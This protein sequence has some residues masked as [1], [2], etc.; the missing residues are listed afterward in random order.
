[1]P[2]LE[3]RESTLELINSEIADAVTRQA[4]A[5]NQVDTKAALLAG[6]AAT[7]TQ[8]LAGGS[9]PAPRP[10]FAILAYIA[11]AIAFASSVAAYAVSK[12]GDVPQ[13]RGLVRECI[14]ATKATTLAHLIATRVQ[15]YE[16][17][18]TKGKR[19]VICWWIAVAALIFGLGLSSI[20]LALGPAPPIATAPAWRR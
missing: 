15:V 3:D 6:V 20:A 5:R 18:Q 4:A 11:Y 10:V 14:T 16:A 19:K 1:M 17:N 12:F 13:P 2:N 7:A 9:H 8:F